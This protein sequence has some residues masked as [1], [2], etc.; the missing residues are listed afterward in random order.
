MGWLRV[1]GTTVALS[2]VLVLGLAACGAE[3]GEQVVRPHDAK[4]V[5]DI[6]M[7][8][9]DFPN[10]HTMTSVRFFFIT[11]LLGHLD[12]ALEVANSHDGGE[13]PVGT[14]IQLVPQE[15]MVKRAPGYNT[16]TND[17]E[18]FFLKV[19]A[20]GTEIV[21]R[22]ADE[23][24]NRFGQNC[25]SCHQAADK[26]FDMVCEQTHGC[27]PLSVGRD[28]LKLFQVNDPRPIPMPGA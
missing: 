20:A 6:D 8:A 23:V 21:N 26:R 10:I 25:A 14:L 22:G 28:I 27:A 15:A 19:S 9:A 2:I 13:Y 5:E 11:N 4:P 3:S 24:V 7:Q 16:A 1:G 17:W 12:K 18:F